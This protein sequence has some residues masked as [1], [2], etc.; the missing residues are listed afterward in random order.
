MEKL[1]ACPF[2]DATRHPITTQAIERMAATTGMARTPLMA[3]TGQQDAMLAMLDFAAPGIWWHSLESRQSAPGI[4]RIIDDL[5]DAINA[6]DRCAS[7]ED[8]DAVE[9]GLTIAWAGNRFAGG[10]L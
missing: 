8:I 4:W 2:V 1:T 5:G 7:V 10:P 9:R 6:L 3:L